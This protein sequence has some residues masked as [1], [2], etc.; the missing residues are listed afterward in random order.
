MKSRGAQ[1]FGMLLLPR[2][3]VSLH[4]LRG[5]DGSHTAPCP[6]AWPCLCLDCI[7]TPNGAVQKWHAV[8]N[9]RTVIYVNFP[10]PRHRAILPARATTN[11]PPGW[12]GKEF[13]NRFN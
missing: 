7:K 3:D 9:R 5:V 2:F 10:F 1:R 13:K 8:L 4:P 11:T 12:E 6:A